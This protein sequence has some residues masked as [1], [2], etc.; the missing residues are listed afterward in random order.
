MTPDIDDY[1]NLL[2]T[3]TGLLIAAGLLILTPVPIICWIGA[4]CLYAGFDHVGYGIIRFRDLTLGGEAMST[5]SFLK[6]LG[7]IVEPRY[8]VLQKLFGA[9]G[10]IALL[11]FR[12]LP[13]VGWVHAALTSVAFS[14]S[15]WLLVCDVI[16]YW[17]DGKPLEPFT[18]W[19]WSPVVWWHKKYT[20][21]DLPREKRAAPV[22][23]VQWS[24]GVGLFIPFVILI[25]KEAGLWQL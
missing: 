21:Q 1:K 18:W 11:F 22:R 25:G 15:A 6:T 5:S 12:L 2:W 20:Q 4:L 23:A 19:D 9:F 13:V 10:V 14:F 8:R 24:A 16:Y 7:E 3:R 17:A